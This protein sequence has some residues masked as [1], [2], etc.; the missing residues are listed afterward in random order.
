M[1]AG[2]RSLLVPM[3]A[4]HKIAAVFCLILLVRN[5]GTLRS[6]HAPAVLP[7]AIAVFAAAYIACLVTGVFQSIPATASSLWLNLHRAAAAI[8]TAGC[9]VAGGL[10][11]MS[12]RG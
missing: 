5:A 8:A 7:A 3:A 1:G 6:F 12:V 10:I 11:A 9:A 2:G 4:V